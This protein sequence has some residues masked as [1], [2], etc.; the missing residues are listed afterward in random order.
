MFI[1]LR[2]GESMII[3]KLKKL[4]AITAQDFD[5]LQRGGRM[6]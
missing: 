3:N 6:I 4:T 5:K 1:H 2:G